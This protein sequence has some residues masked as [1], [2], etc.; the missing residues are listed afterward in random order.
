VGTLFLARRYARTRKAFA[1]QSLALSI[2]KKWEWADM[3]APKDLHEALLIHQARS[4]QR[5]SGYAQVL[6]VYQEAIR[7]ILADGIV[8]REEFQRLESLRNQLQIKQADH[9]RIMASLAETDRALFEETA[10]RP[11]AEKLLQLQTY[12]LALE[13]H[14][15]LE[16]G[17]G[18][19]DDR[20]LR[21][22][23][24]EYNVTPEEH[25]AHLDAVLGGAQGIAA[26]VADA[27]RQAVQPLPLIRALSTEASPAYAF[28]ADLLRRKRA[29]AVSRLVRLL[30]VD[31]KTPDGRAIYEGLGSDD[32][33]SREQACGALLDQASPAVAERMR[34]MRRELAASDPPTLVASLL[35]L[36]ASPDPYV[37]AATIYALAGGRPL[38]MDRGDE[39][40][41]LVQETLNALRARTAGITTLE[42]MIALR[43]VPIFASLE[44]ESLAALA[45]P[46]NEESYAP[47]QILVMEGDP[48]DDAFII[49]SGSIR[50]VLKA[51][52]ANEVL[53]SER[54]AGDIMGEMAV[55]DPAPRSATLRAGAG[56]VRVL[57]ISGTTLREAL[58]TDPDVATGIIG[59][60]VRR[61]RATLGR[62][63]SKQAA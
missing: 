2:L 52:T 60:L 21:Q 44:P 26:Q 62:V 36:V 20:L 10:A 6:D 42:K 22:L 61:L 5:Q 33:G 38:D 15:K 40:H 13:Q 24:R 48:G 4:S 53:V 47:D 23:Q 55:L 51:G 43:S 57:A 19:A 37:R 59:T 46:S 49:L 34:A 1:E 16:L 27:L 12:H 32:D 8:T 28:L 9:E 17:T 45:R 54:G 25:A 50:V 39:E 58:R 35:E 11:S 3:R 7:E 30:H 56:G 31:I 63:E 41:P 18:A 29:Q 14:L